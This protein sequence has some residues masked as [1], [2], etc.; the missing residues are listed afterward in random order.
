MSPDGRHVYYLRGAELWR[1]DVESGAESRVGLSVS[2]WSRFAVTTHGIYFIPAGP[3]P[4]GAELV[5]DFL[6]FAT[7]KIQNVVRLDKPPFIG[8]TVSA[9]ERWL[10]LSQT[11][12]TG[13]DLM[14]VENFR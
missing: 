1:T 2:D 7:G 6:D 9:D 8:M 11:D 4:N 14:L 13:A 5:I 3:G 10:L 12:Q